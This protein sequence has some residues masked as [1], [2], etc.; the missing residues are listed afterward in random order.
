MGK[1]RKSGIGDALA[2]FNATYGMTKGYMQDSAMKDIADAKQEEFT[3][4]EPTFVGMTGSLDEQDI[5]T[6][7]K[8]GVKFLGK[9]YD[10]PLTDADQDRARMQAMSGVFSKF[11]DPM[12]AMEMKSKAQQ[13]EL[14]GLQLEGAKRDD[15]YQ[16]GWGKVWA[17]TDLAK[18]Q[19]EGRDATIGEQLSTA[20]TLMQHK[21]AHGKLDPNELTSYAEKMANLRSEGYAGAMRVLNAGGSPEA[22]AAEFNKSGKTQV[23]PSQMAIRPVKVKVNGK[24]IDTYELTILKDGKAQV[25]NGFRELDGLGKADGFFSRQLQS[26]ADT[27]GDKQIG[28]QESELELRK[29]AEGRAAN[30]D[31]RAAVTFN[32]GA[33]ERNNKAEVERL[34]AV[35]AGLP[36]DSPERAKNIQKINDLSGSGGVDQHAPSEVKLANAFVKA[37]LVPSMAEGLKMATQGKDLSPDK[38]RFEIYKTALTANMGD[39][40][41]AKETTDQVMS[42]FGTSNAA[43]APARSVGTE[44]VIQS[45]PNKGKTAV[46]DGQGWKLKQ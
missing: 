45:G 11:G 7:A 31:N 38:M 20:S 12:K 13:A 21:A 29:K 5:P 34:K 30:A 17:G 18:A 16:K 37:G 33:G 28:I 23:D 36:I 25:I 1:K 46:W 3:R 26:N 19:S 42:D 6:V 9:E 41:R 15:E 8:T 22:I 44:Q 40:K 32:S 39:A 10:K 24:D 4:N 43:K 35:T 27:R 14:Q 2:A